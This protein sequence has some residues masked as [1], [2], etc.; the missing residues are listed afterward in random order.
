MLNSIEKLSETDEKTNNINIY[1]MPN[2]QFTETGLTTNSHNSSTNLF[3]IKNQVLNRTL[4]HMSY[5]SRDPNDSYAYNDV[6][7]YI[8]ENELMSPEKE[9][10]IQSWVSLV[11]SQK[12]NWEKNLIE[13]KIEAQ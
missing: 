10:S 11:N 13:L 1:L 5:K 3:N 2:K 4:S 6:K 12:D 9:K 8:E 7:K